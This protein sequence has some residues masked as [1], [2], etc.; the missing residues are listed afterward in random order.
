MTA[1]AMVFAVSAV[2]VALP[3]SSRRRLRALF[4]EPDDRATQ[5]R[6]GLSDPRVVR[7][8]SAV[9]GLGIAVSVGGI[10][11]WGSGLAIAVGAP[12]AVGRLESRRDRQ[13]REAMERQGADAADLLAACLAS[14]APISPSAAAVARALGDPIAQPLGTLVA[15][16]SLG[17]DPVDA[18]RALMHQPGMEALSRAV[19]RSLESGAPLAQTLPGIAEDLRRATRGQ[20]EAAARAAGVRAVAP[21]AACFLPAFLLVGVVPIVASL[22]IPFLT[23]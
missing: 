5:S 8:V 20:V 12:I 6:P 3:A 16:L 19:A 10:W 4:T 18:W 21:L 23:R 13:R 7:I 14:G 1:M 9:G 22:A 17:A 2:L 11:G 15:S